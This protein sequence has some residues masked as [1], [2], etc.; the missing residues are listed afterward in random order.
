MKVSRIGLAVI[1]EIPITNKHRRAETYQHRQDYPKGF[2]SWPS[3][4]PLP[5]P[6]LPELPP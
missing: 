3:P 6:A 4:E 2:S 1:R 5:L